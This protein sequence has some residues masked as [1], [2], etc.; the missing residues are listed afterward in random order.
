MHLRFKP[1]CRNLVSARRPTACDAVRKRLRKGG[2]S[3]QGCQPTRRRQRRNWR[4]RA[5]ERGQRSEPA[6]LRAHPGLYYFEPEKPARTQIPRNVWDT[7]AA[8]TAGGVNYNSERNLAKRKLAPQKDGFPTVSPARCWDV[9]RFLRAC[10]EPEQRVGAGE[11]FDWFERICRQRMCAF[12]CESKDA[13]DPKASK[14]RA[15]NGTN[16]PNVSIRNREEACERE[17]R[18]CFRRCRRTPR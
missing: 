7:A 2:L 14:Q 17:S 8:G 1:A 11:L 4:V 9:G 12:L 6:W 10:A 16:E 18:R 13:L 15:R 3:Q 5:V